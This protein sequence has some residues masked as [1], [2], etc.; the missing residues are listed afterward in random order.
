MRDERGVAGEAGPGADALEELGGLGHE[1]ESGEAAGAK[2]YV[3]MQI[4][5]PRKK[6]IQVEEIRLRRMKKGQD[7]SRSRLISEAVDLLA[8]RE[9]G[10]KG[11]AKE[12]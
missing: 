4:F 9:S 7:V 5:L 10:G 12:N 11:G 8:E 2:R 3:P 6:A 1:A